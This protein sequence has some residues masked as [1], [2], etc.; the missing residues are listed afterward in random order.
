M[1]LRS[2]ESLASPSDATNLPERRNPFQTN[3]LQTRPYQAKLIRP[4]AV[5]LSEAEGPAFLSTLY[6]ASG[7][8]KMLE[9]PEKKRKKGA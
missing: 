2:F 1:T 8:P 3:L 7:K 5:I 6:N 4:K 9:A